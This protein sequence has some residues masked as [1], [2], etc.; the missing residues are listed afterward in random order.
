MGR[1]TDIAM[2]KHTLPSEMKVVLYFTV[3]N[4]TYFEKE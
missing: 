3:R 4:Q 2:H 1:I